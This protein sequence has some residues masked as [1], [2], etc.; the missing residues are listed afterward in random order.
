MFSSGRTIVRRGN[1]I[2]GP[3]SVRAVP[4]VKGEGRQHGAGGTAAAAKV[5]NKVKCWIRLASARKY[6]QHIPSHSVA[7]DALKL[8]HKEVAGE[9]ASSANKHTGTHTH[10]DT[11]T[12][13]Y[14]C[15]TR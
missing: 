5:R 3:V 8:P 10:T 15:Y 12:P 6:G 7:R 2:L 11:S 1:I 9:V 4:P 14:V 13:V